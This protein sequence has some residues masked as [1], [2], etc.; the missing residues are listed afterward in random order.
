MTKKG[1]NF[2][3]SM[4]TANIILCSENQLSP[5]NAGLSPFNHLTRL[6]ARQS[7]NE[8]SRRERIRLQKL[9]LLHKH[10]LMK[11]N[12]NIAKLETPQPLHCGYAALKRQNSKNILNFVRN[13]KNNCRMWN[14][15]T[16]WTA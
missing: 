11:T 15:S 9:R 3:S 4:E 2:P 12:T 10:K 8:F 6:T 7:V 1:L 13:I 16:I 5:R 14:I